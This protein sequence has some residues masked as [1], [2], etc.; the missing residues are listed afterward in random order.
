MEKLIQELQE[1]KDQSEAAKEELDRFRNQSQNLQEQIQVQHF[2]TFCLKSLFLVLIRYTERHCK[3][4]SSL[5]VPQH[6]YFK[7][8]E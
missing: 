6:T 2:Y 7:F 4:S 8:N 5:G 3:V 1:V